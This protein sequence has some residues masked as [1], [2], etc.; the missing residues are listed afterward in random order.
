MI[1]YQKYYDLDNILF[2]EISANFVRSGELSAE[3]FWFIL[4]WKANRAKNYAKIRLTRD[5]TLQA[6]VARI[7]ST[8]HAASCGKDRLNILM[9]E[10]GFSLPTASAILSVLYP[11][12]FTVFDVRVCDSLRSLGV[13]TDFKPLATQQFSDIFWERYCE[14]IDAVK[15]N[16][17]PNLSLRDKDRYL[18]GKSR[19]EDVVQEV[20]RPAKPI[21]RKLSE[22]R[23]STG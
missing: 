9:R 2:P 16:S 12:E 4:I 1:E 15:A 14:F 20:R 21:K 13:S 18:W 23:P 22:K 6:S 19:F 11:N 10:W 3:H 5:S 7:A 8:L 17:P